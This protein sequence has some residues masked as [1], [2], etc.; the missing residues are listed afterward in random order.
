MCLFSVLSSENCISG[1]LYL[2]FKKNIKLRKNIIEKRYF[3]PYEAM[4]KV[5]CSVISESLKNSIFICN[6]IKGYNETL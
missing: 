1:I 6:N 2:Q 4:V 5:P 3:C